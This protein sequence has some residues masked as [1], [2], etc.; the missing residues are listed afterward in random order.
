MI[1]KIQTKDMTREEWLSARDIGL[2]GSDAAVALGLS[3]FKTPFELWAEK[4]GR[5][6]KQEPGRLAEWGNKL[7]DVVAQAYTDLTGHKVQRDNFMYVDREK[8]LVSNIDRRVV[9]LNR[10]LEVK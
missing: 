9:G 3:K 8:G 1:E 6:E 2:G 10:L 4:T 5:L 7:E